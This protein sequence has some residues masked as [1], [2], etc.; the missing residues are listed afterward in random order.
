MLEISE[1]RKFLK[2][3]K[4]WK[5]KER[6]FV[7]FGIEIRRGDCHPSIHRSCLIKRQKKEM[8]SGSRDFI[9]IYISK[10]IILKIMR[11]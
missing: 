1:I 2:F 8:D 11:K 5:A 10:S 6:N 3:W 7:N 4:F 9:Y